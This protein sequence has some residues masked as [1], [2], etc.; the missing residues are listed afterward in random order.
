[1]TV[2]ELI[3]K[4][5]EFP[6]GAA[7]HLAYPSGDYLRTTLAPP[8]HRIGMGIVQTTAP[9]KCPVYCQPGE[10]HSSHRLVDDS[11]DPSVDDTDARVVVLQ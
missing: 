2:K 9:Q 8:I 4:L 5:E 7:V 1:M 6:D 10:Y 3:A 11:D